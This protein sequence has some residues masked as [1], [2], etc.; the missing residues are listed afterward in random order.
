LSCSAVVQAV[1]GNHAAGHA[2]AQ[3]VKTRLFTGVANDGGGGE[4]AFIQQEITIRNS[5]G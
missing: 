5:G 4:N 2:S 1:F 3:V